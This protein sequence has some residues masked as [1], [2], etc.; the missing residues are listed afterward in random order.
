MFPVLIE[1]PF[2]FEYNP[3]RQKRKFFPIFG[4]PFNENYIANDQ[5]ISQSKMP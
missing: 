5:N 4:L 2:N 3:G 1:S